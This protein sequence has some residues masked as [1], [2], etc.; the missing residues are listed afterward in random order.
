M[1]RIEFTARREWSR[2]G[3]C[4]VIRLEWAGG[5]VIGF[6]RLEEMERSSNPAEGLWAMHIREALK[7]EEGA[8]DE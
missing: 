5:P 8:R 2:I 7:H 6:D 1:G 4:Y 3:R